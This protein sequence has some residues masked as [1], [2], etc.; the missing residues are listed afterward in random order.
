MQIRGFPRSYSLAS[1]FARHP[2]WCIPLTGS[3]P[4]V[5]GKNKKGTKACLPQKYRFDNRG[6]A[7]SDFMTSGRIGNWAGSLFHAAFL[8][9]HRGLC[10]GE[11]YEEPQIIEDVLRLTQKIPWD[12]RSRRSWAEEPCTF[13][14]ILSA[15]HTGGACGSPERACLAEAF[16]AQPP[17]L[18]IKV[19]GCP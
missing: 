14:C 7:G 12:G 19:C 4:T 17:A 11:V 9:F 3:R 5:T 2:G 13:Q 16:G 6:S 1:E 15:R 10:A 8:L 18:C